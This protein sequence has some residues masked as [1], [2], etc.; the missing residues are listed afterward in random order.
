LPHDRREQLAI[1]AAVE[2]QRKQEIIMAQ[3]G[4]ITAGASGIGKEI[5]RA[6]A[7]KGAKVCVC[8]I[9]AEALNAAAKDIPDLKTVVCDVS[10]REDIGRMVTASVDSLGGL[11]VLVNNAGIAGQTASVED[12]DPDHGRR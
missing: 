1:A 4:L 6:Y 7:V 5:A 10:K 9:S 3:R 12:A 11:D 2:K 8:D